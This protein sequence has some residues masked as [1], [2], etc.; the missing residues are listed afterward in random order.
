ML[1]A[2]AEARSGDP[3]MVDGMDAEIP[4]QEK[5]NIAEAFWQP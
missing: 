4:T 3:R 1:S 5:L 2:I